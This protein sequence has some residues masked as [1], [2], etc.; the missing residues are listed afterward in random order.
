MNHTQVL[1]FHAIAVFF[2]RI[3]LDAP[4]LVQIRD[5]LRPGGFRR[6]LGRVRDRVR[7]RFQVGTITITVCFPML[8]CAVD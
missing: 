3:C 1:S 5:P 4:V 8:L 7:I 6:A 2:C